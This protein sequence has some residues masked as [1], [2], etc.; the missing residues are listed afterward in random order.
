MIIKMQP[1]ENSVTEVLEKVETL[2][3]L[4]ILQYIPS[5]YRK[6]KK[7]GRCF[8]PLQAVSSDSGAESFVSLSHLVLLV[9]QCRLLPATG[10]RERC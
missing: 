2:L 8:Y 5:V 7:W 6:Q 9:S 10:G 3:L 4:A 1:R